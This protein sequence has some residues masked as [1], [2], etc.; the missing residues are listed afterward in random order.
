MSSF[1]L[2]STISGRDAL[3]RMAAPHIVEFLRALLLPIS[4]NSL[5]VR[6]SK[7]RT[8]ISSGITSESKRSSSHLSSWLYPKDILGQTSLPRPAI[9][10]PNQVRGKT[11]SKTTLQSELKKSKTESG[12]L[13]FSRIDYGAVDPK[14]IESMMGVQ[15][16][17]DNSSLPKPLLELVRM[18]ASQIN[19]CAYC[20]DMHSK[21]ARTEGE[22]E[23]RLYLLNAWREA[24]LYTDQER[25]ALAWTEA[26]TLVSKSHVPDKV[27]EVV[28]KYFTEKEIVEL[29]MAII[30]INSWNRLSISMGHVAGT[31]Q[32][33]SRKP[34]AGKS[35]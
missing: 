16:Y 29:T 34:H 23:Q 1:R 2:V 12:K 21:D 14:A 26:V 15:R 18:R 4:G 27:Y 22:S 28:R 20:L 5:F 9:P 19:G 31:Y 17:V 6:R 10:N 3:H 13:R 24:P 8:Q 11:L 30:A 35:E 7:G 32:P 33:A 25:A